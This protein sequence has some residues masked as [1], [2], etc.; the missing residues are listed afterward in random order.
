MSRLLI[1]TH[2]HGKLRELQDAVVPYVDEV[3]TLD[4]LKIFDEPVE[5]GETFE[6]NSLLKANFYWRRSNIPTLADDGGL[7]I[8]ALG[9][10]PGVHSRRSHGRRLSDEELR[11]EIL[12]LLQGIPEDKRTAQLRTVVTLRVSQDQNFQAELSHQG[13]I[14]E[15]NL[16]IDPGYPFRAIFWLPELKKFYSQLTPEENQRL[17]HRRRAVEKLIPY[18]QQYL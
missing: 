16:P 13:I 1:A 17:N 11:L 5:D 4:E 15:S 7:E 10:K 18:L 2:N 12:R 6:E 9:G 3:V 8:D 14:R